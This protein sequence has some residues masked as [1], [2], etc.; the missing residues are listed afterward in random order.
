M[1]PTLG[2]FSQLRAFSVLAER[3]N[4]KLAANSSQSLS[5]VRRI[6]KIK[7]LKNHFFCLVI[8]SGQ[9]WLLCGRLDYF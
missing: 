7:D 5:D 4:L 8:G 9:L 2:C 3:V 6:G 1:N